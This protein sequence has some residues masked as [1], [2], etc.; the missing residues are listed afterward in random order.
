MQFTPP[1]QGFNVRPRNENGASK[2]I[3]YLHLNV[4]CAKEF[5]RNHA[6]ADVLFLLGG[7]VRSYLSAREGF[8]V[9]TGTSTYVQ[10]YDASET[11]DGFYVRIAL[12]TETTPRRVQSVVAGA[13]YYLAEYLGEDCIAY[14]LAFVQSQSDLIENTTLEGLT[15]P[16]AG[17]WAPF[18]PAFFRTYDKP[19]DDTANWAHV[20]GGHGFLGAQRGKDPA[21]FLLDRAEIETLAR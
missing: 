21:R 15:G 17:D 6:R 16:K 5:T 14:R 1:P 8:K 18:N 9:R 7:M 19:R 3:A 12:N 2:S 11:H 20:G 10:W 4:E 13:I